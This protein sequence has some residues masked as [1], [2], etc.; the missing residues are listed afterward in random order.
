[1]GR[2]KKNVEVESEDSEKGDTNRENKVLRQY[3]DGNE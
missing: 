2:R 3:L 1:M